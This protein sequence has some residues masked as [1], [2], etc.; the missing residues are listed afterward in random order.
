[1]TKYLQGLRDSQTRHWRKKGE[2]GKR[3]NQIYIY[4]YTYIRCVGVTSG[5]KMSK[6]KHGTHKQNE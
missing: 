4:M 6:Q 2:R 3:N 5:K 1:M